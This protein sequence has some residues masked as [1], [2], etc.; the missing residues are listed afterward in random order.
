MRFA[1][2]AALAQ[3]PRPATSSWPDGVRDVD[4]HRHGSML[5]EAFA[6]R[7]VDHQTPHDQDE[8]YFVVR[9]EA[10]FVTGDGSSPSMRAR[11]R[12]G[13]ALF[14]AA[15]QPHHFTG[16]SDD[17]ATWVVFWGP[18]GGEAPDVAGSSLSPGGS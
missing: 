6:P 7:G 14:V 16:M 4:V 9:G 12:P 10:D 5:L 13:D 15:H 3:L 17:F 1:L 18:V 2:D 8:L 11:C